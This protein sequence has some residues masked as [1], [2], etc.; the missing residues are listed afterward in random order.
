[1]RKQNKTFRLTEEDRKA[2]TE[3]AELHK[4][5][6]SKILR[7]FLNLPQHYPTINQAL[8]QFL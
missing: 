8:R 4:T 3:L 5:N 2:L 7:A 1:M 6:D